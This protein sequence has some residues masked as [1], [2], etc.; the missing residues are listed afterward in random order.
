MTDDKKRSS[1]PLDFAGKERNVVCSCQERAINF[2]H[3]IF[4]AF[5]LLALPFAAAP[6]ADLAQIGQA[7]AEFS[8]PSQE[9]GPVSLKAFRGQWV[10][11]YFY[12][13]DMTPGCTIEAHNFQ[14]D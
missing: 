8:L 13:K 1:V 12:P 5:A 4:T 11:L 14:R 7:P 6:A 9:G 10:V 2:R 3:R